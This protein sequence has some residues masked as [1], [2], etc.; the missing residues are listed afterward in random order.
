MTTSIPKQES[1]QTLARI[2]EITATAFLWAGSAF[3]F[4]RPTAHQYILASFLGASASMIVNLYG[5]LLVLVVVGFAGTK[6]HTTLLFVGGITCCWIRWVMFSFAGIG[7]ITPYLAG[8]YYFFGGASFAFYVI[9]WCQHFSE[10]TETEKKLFI[11]PSIMY[12]L[13]FTL[14]LLQLPPTV[15]PF[16]NCVLQTIAVVL[17]IAPSPARSGAEEKTHF[18]KQRT[19]IF[20]LFGFMIG[21]LMVICPRMTSDTVFDPQSSTVLAPLWT[22]LVFV[23]ATGSFLYTGHKDRGSGI[24]QHLFPLIVLGLIAPPFLAHGLNGIF[25]TSIIFVVLG[26]AIVFSSGDPGS[27]TVWSYKNFQFV[28]WER[29]IVLVGFALGSLGAATI[30]SAVRFSDIQGI[31]FAVAVLYTALC[32]I[33]LSIPKKIL[34]KKTGGETYFEL[35]HKVSEK[36]AFDYALTP[37]EQ[38]V[39]HELSQ[40]RSVPYIQEKLCISEGTAASHINHIHQ[41]LGVHK[42][43]ELLDV[44]QEYLDKEMT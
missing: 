11:A 39:F 36:I 6:K 19:F 18:T 42:R 33:T 27:C 44:T 12:A 43:Q 8:A 1:P 40:G 10:K 5:I 26:E 23:I 32:L 37:R 17:L 21:C 13:F 31:L 30:G 35:L 24:S 20:L 38:E 3:S 22:V 7:E 41:K 34:E 25:P 2:K 29:S 14:I 4:V 9:A 15:A 16:L 28:F